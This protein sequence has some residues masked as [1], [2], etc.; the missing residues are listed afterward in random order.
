MGKFD[1][2]SLAGDVG[3]KLGGSLFDAALG[4]FNSKNL[5]D[6]QQARQEKFQKQMLLQSPLLNARGLKSAGYNINF[7]D[8]AAASSPAVPSI[9]PSSKDS[10]FGLT[11]VLALQNM[12]E[13][14][15]LIKEQA[16][17]LKI[18]N[19]RKK[20][21]DN[22]Y[23]ADMY[24]V[25][26]V[27]Y[28]ESDFMQLP[29]D[30]RNDMDRVVP[31]GK[32]TFRSKGAFEAYQ[33]VKK[34]RVEQDE[35]NNR[36]VKSRLEKFITDM[37]MKDNDVVNSLYKLPS[38]QLKEIISKTKESLSKVGLNAALKEQAL[39]N[40]ELIDLTHKLKEETNLMP[41]IDKIFN[42]NIDTKDIVKFLLLFIA[43]SF[44]RDV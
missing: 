1:F 40:K 31:I 17:A 3:L 37:Q 4:N 36:S 8:G 6:Y 20:D 35:L 18:D 7:S 23:G 33:A 10:H 30:V 21:E 32:G 41:Y 27:L 25:D 12:R 2:A 29:D 34:W 28:P 19:D 26:G 42:G 43:K 44:N 39:S 9:T 24:E 14:N 16:R 13:Q 11:D 5:F 38:Y 15:N 22:R